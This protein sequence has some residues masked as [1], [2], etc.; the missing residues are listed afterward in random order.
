M[1]SRTP[2]PREDLPDIATGSIEIGRRRAEHVHAVPAG[3]PDHCDL[4]EDRRE[5]P[6]VVAELGA[7]APYGTHCIITPP[8]GQVVAARLGSTR[9]TRS[10]R[11]PELSI[12]GGGSVTM[13]SNRSSV[14]SRWF[15]PSATITRPARVGQDGVGIGVVPA[16][17]SPG[18]RRDE[19]D[20]IGPQARRSARC[21]TP[22]PSRTP[23]RAPAR[24]R[25]ARSA[26]GSA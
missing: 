24:H 9:T 23:R 7:G 14:S 3:A 18:T 1:S 8:G 20:G 25:G 4:R 5:G 12:G 17:T 15:R 21:G 2:G 16:G 6:D 19:L 26:A 10:P 11:R 13:M 22:N